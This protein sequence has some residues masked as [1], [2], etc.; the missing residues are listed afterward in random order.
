M[1]NRKRETNEIHGRRTKS[2]ARDQV[3]NEH[4]WFP[5]AYSARTSVRPSDV[6]SC[7]RSDHLFSLF[8]V[9][10]VSAALS[11]N[12]EIAKGNLMKLDAT[13]ARPGRGGIKIS[14]ELSHRSN[15]KRLRRRQTARPSEFAR[16]GHERLCQSLLGLLI[17]KIALETPYQSVS[18]D[19]DKR[20]KN[21]KSGVWKVL[22]L[23]MAFRPE[24]GVDWFGTSSFS[25]SSRRERETEAA[26]KRRPAATGD[27]RRRLSMPT[28]N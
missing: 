28:K 10:C 27:R 4:K 5:R 7:W 19:K 25:C 22:A 13:P 17:G 6:G 14:H 16:R 8:L 2:V 26:A 12:L 18:N 21:Q 24:S 20:G 15:S 1:I 11:R 23:F 9:A 3:R